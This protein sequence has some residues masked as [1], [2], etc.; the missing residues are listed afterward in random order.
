MCDGPTA[1]C[2]LY[3]YAA[4]GDRTVQRAYLPCGLDAVLPCEAKR[5][6]PLYIV[7]VIGG[8]GGRSGKGKEAVY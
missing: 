3:R 6:P 7:K 1:G 4:S 5:L 8:H 2:A